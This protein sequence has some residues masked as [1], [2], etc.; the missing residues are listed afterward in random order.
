MDSGEVGATWQLSQ[1]TRRIGSW[2]S[3]PGND[4]LE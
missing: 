4:I 2:V 1:E 3:D